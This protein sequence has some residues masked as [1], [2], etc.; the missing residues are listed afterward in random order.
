MTTFTFINGAP[1]D[2]SGSFPTGFV[3]NDILLSPSGLFSG[4]LQGDGNFVVFYGPKP[5]ASGTKVLWSSGQSNPGGGPFSLSWL[6]GPGT[7][8]QPTVSSYYVQGIR[9]NVNSFYYTLINSYPSTPESTFLQLN[10]NGSL[11]MY[12]GTSGVATGSAVKTIG[13]TASLQSLTLTSL[14]Y[15]LAKAT[16]PE[17]DK[18]YG[19]TQRL[20]NTT[21][22]TANLTAQ[23]SLTYANTQSYDWG[24]SNTVTR[25]ITSA[26]TI[27]LPVIGS[28]ELSL[29]LS[30]ST[31]ISEGQST[32]SGTETTYLSQVSTPVPPRTTYGIQIYATQQDA[33]VPFTYTGFYDFGEGPIPAS[34]SGEFEGVSTGIFDAHVYC[35]SSPDSCTSAAKIPDFPAPPESVPEPPSLAALLPAVL[36]LGTVLAVRK[37]RARSGQ[38]PA[39][40]RRKP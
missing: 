7:G 12:R 20:T 30:G 40:P 32:S 29:S 36:A 22:T 37:R 33:L 23:L 16:F 10:D 14:Q 19:T 9:N 13:N 11:S 39:S 27:K 6:G 4:L 3:E 15:D 2:F 18:I 26:T 28:T 5:Y 25:S 1:V 17:V 24:T 38:R 35:I 34:G 21:P 31:T 8:G